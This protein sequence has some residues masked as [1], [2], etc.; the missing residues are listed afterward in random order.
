M[1]RKERLDNV[2]QFPVG[3][4]GFVRAAEKKHPEKLGGARQRNLAHGFVPELF[5]AGVEHGLPVL[6]EEVLF[7]DTKEHGN[8][9]EGHLDMPW[10][11]DH[12][13]CLWEDQLYSLGPVGVVHLS[14]RH[15]HHE[16]KPTIRK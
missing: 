7:A 2:V 14:Q 5:P 1:R 16:C 6:H 13:A 10:L 9:W 11:V 15:L 12:L 8:E 4:I 3:C